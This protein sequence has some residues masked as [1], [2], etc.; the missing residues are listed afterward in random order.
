MAGLG[1]RVNN[2]DRKFVAETY[3]D[4]SVS[5]GVS[6]GRVMQPFPGFPAPKVNG[7]VHL[8]V[9]LLLGVL[10]LGSVGVHFGLGRVRGSLEV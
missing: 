3:V 4:A 6:S 7:G 8:W 9:W 1:A 5:S 2:A 10:V